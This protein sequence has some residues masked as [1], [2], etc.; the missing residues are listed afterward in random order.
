MLIFSRACFAWVALL[1]AS[2]ASLAPISMNSD[3]TLPPAAPREFR[4]MWVATVANIDWPSRTGLSTA[5]Q[6]QEIRKIVAVAK[7]LKM[8]ALILQVRPAA[9]AL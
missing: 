1:L 9:D 5:E 3:S 8:N 6:Q 2:C 7:R 4:A